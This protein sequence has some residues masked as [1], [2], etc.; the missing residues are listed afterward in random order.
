VALRA[1]YVVLYVSQ[2][3]RLAPSP[4]I[5]RYFLGMRPE[6]TVDVLGVPYAWIYPGP[7]LIRVDVPPQAT[8]TNIGL[9]DQLRLAGYLITH[10]EVADSAEN[11]GSSSPVSGGQTVSNLEVALFWH[12]LARMTND[13]TISV[14]LVAP[15]GRWLAQQDSW[16]AGG[17]LPT[18]QWRQADYVQDV[19]TLQ[20]P[21]DATVDRVQVVVYDAASKQPLGA[22]IELPVVVERDQ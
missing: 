2:V 9:G 20:V 4:E 10:R 14:R 6:H 13:Y 17:L 7:K 12:A 3:Q 11:S 16:P 5:V 1:D 19:H 15:N 8:L 21:P 22:P 18:S